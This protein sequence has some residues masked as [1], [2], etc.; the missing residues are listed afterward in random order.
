MRLP[1]WDFHEIQRET[2]LVFANRFF[3]SLL[4]SFSFS[5]FYLSLYVNQDKVVKHPLSIS[6]LFLTTVLNELCIIGFFMKFEEQLTSV[7]SVKDLPELFTKVIQRWEVLAKYFSLSH[8]ILFSIS[9]IFDIS[10]FSGFPF[11]CIFHT[12]NHIN[13]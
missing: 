11:F 8:F 6:L 1:V 13:K 5:F 7:L 3:L 9:K 2:A 4:I 10:C 12:W